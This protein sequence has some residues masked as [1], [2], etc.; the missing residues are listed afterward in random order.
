MK[1]WKTTLV[2]IVAGTLTILQATLAAYQSGAPVQWLQVALG[3]AVMAL[4]VVAK[5]F[6]I[7]GPALALLFVGL[8]P[9]GC[10]LFGA[11]QVKTGQCFDYC[12]VTVIEL[13]QGEAAICYDSEAKMLAAKQSLEAKGLTV[14]VRK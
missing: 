9:T 14:T 11:P 10:G 4:G 6:N 2:G 12:L 7:S 1:N 8:A 13:T 5:D 3:V